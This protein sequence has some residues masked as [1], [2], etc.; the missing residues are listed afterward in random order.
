MA[1]PKYLLT[2]AES[3][4][5]NQ[6]TAGTKKDRNPSWCVAFVRFK[7]PGAMFRGDEDPFEER[8]LLVVENDCVSVN[9]NNPK[10]GFA[11]TASLT[12]KIGEV[13]Y[14]NAV[15]PGDYVF[16]WMA[17]EQDDIDKILN[18]LFNNEN[19]TPGSTGKISLNGF[20]SG[21]KFFGR[22]MSVPHADQMTVN[23]QRI[24]GQQVNCQSFL[25]LASSIYYTF[26]AQNILSL[27]G[28]LRSQAAS[29]NFYTKEIERI[30]GP[31]T[32]QT[33][34]TQ[35]T[36]GVSNGLETAL[37]NLSDAFLNFY[38]RTDGKDEVTGDTSPEAIIGLLFIITMGI[39]ASSSLV[40]NA[41]P[42]A[43]GTFSD[44]IG[45]PKSVVNILGRKGN[46][47]WQMYNLYLGLQEY[48]AKGQNTAEDFSPIFTPESLT[49]GAVFYRTPTKCKGFIPFLVPPI[50]DNNNF[51]NIFNQFLNPI[52]NEMYTALRVNREGRILP[53]LIVR[54]KPFS[55]GL[56][57]FLLKKAPLFT[58]KAVKDT[59][60]SK[61]TNALKQQIASENQQ[62]E[63]SRKEYEKIAKANPEVTKRT[64]YRNIPRW[65]VDES[66][67]VGI[68]VAPDESRRINFVQVWGRSRGVEFIGANISQEVLKQAQFMV[69]NY[70]AD[71]GDIKRHG[72]R[73]DITE[74]NYD[75]VSSSFG[76]ISHILCRQRAD[77]LMNGHLKPFGTI[78]LQGVQEPICE[79]DNIQVR[80]ILFH[81]EA[82]SHN[83]SLSSDG[84]KNFKTTVTV[85]NGILASSLDSNDGV[86]LYPTA[87]ADKSFTS[88][89]DAPYNHPG[90]TDVQNTGPRKGRNTAGEKVEGDGNET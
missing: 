84:K 80:G 55:T 51:W 33:S 20:M 77:W 54:E 2:A 4:S 48:N 85:S 23:G 9:V 69:P 47:L 56:F 39:D 13:F 62:Q 46:K 78:T 41:I 6:D 86:P 29:T 59:S 27:D 26:I 18:S 61:A 5:W 40:N 11:K 88:Q 87:D 3:G 76:T 21:L 24:L 42:G 25:E 60:G 63:I 16:V 12:M 64:L 65:V 19:G 38:R 70:V 71:E 32:P 10:N 73:A 66:V 75:V 68:N 17:N 31:K 28:G 22:V 34:T 45:V 90:F 57:D 15:A 37:T 8:K 89:L 50:W 72:L 82:V 35:D 81:I 7:T 67:L 30:G 53:T 83:S 79:G 14:Q 58:Q 74:T 1:T 49:K 52:V 36:K 44:A 43:R